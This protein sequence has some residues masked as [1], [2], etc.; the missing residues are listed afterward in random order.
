MDA[1]GRFAMFA[2]M[3]KWE[4]LSHSN[5]IRTYLSGPTTLHHK[6][7]VFLKCEKD[8][9]VVTM[10]RT[11][12]HRTWDILAGTHLVIETLTP[13]KLTF[14]G[15]APRLPRNSTLS[16]SQEEQAEQAE[17]KRFLTIPSKTKMI[18]STLDDVSK[19]VFWGTPEHQ[20]G[21][22]LGELEL[23]PGDDCV[24]DAAVFEEWLCRCGQSNCF[25]QHRVMAV[26]D[27]S[28]LRNFLFNAVKGPRSPIATNSFV[29]GMYF[30]LL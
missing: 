30:P 18:I 25:T 10:M 23:K 6:V 14:L 2:N 20:D 24:M 19:I 8:A 1:A 11:A 27:A 22:R 28:L 29:L 5:L 16:L 4:A 15:R 13:T 3:P 9:E 17:T 21:S 26:N 7:E 12:N